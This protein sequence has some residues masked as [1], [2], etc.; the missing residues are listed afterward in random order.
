MTK[1]Y[2]DTKSKGRIEFC[3]H[4]ENQKQANRAH[5]SFMSLNQSAKKCG[6][7]LHN[8]KKQEPF[9]FIDLWNI[10]FHII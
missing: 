7:D 9:L 8:E 2:L 5:A 6:G 3:V 4:K 1:N 10:G